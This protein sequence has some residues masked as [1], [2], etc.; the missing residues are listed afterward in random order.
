MGKPVGIICVAFAAI[1]FGSTGVIYSGE[2]DSYFGD[3]WDIWQVESGG[4]SIVAGEAC[5]LKALAWKVL[6]TERRKGSSDRWYELGDNWMKWGWKAVAE[7]PLASA[8]RVRMT[9]NLVSSEGFRLDS[10]TIG[11]TEGTITDASGKQ[12]KTVEIGVLSGRKREGIE[13][14]SIR[15]FQAT[16]VFN[17]SDAEGEG[18]PTKLSVYFDCYGD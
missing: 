15:T 1:A 5:N 9:V 16:S 8:V 12:Q 4:E 7:N 3:G 13:P 2:F 17:L 18:S 6:S 14:S 11:L 10:S